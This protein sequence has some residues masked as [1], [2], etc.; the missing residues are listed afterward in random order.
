MKKIEY[1]NIRA[2]QI[3]KMDIYLNILMNNNSLINSFEND[4]NSNLIK[5]EDN[6]KVLNLMKFLIKWKMKKKFF[7]LMIKKIK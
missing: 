1:N 2:E 6:E 7:Y 5:T 4:S 3:K